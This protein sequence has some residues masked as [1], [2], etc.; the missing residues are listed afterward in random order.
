MPA[1]VQMLRSS[2][3]KSRSPKESNLK[4][5]NLKSV[6]SDGARI[7]TEEYSGV[8]TWFYCICHRPALT[9]ADTGDRIKYIK[10]VE[11]ILKE[12]WHFLRILQ[13]PPLFS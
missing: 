5:R 3:V 11:T 13:K 9:C 8:A 12:T 10:E 6:V 1:K 4:V 2:L 7:M